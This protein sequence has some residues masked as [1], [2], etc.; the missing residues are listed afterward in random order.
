M[1][2]E[3]LT[4]EK[5]QPA[6]GSVRKAKRVG[7]G[8]GSGHGDRATRGNKGAQS[9]S[10]YRKKP[11]FE[12]GQMPLVRRV[13][14]RGFRPLIRVKWDEVGVDQILQIDQEEI[15]P[16]VL[17]KWGLVSGN[18]PVVIIGGKG[19]VKIERPLKVAAHRITQSVRDL[20]EQA[21]GEVT[22]LELPSQ[23]RKVK[24]GPKSRTVRA[25][26]SSRSSA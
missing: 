25:P 17:A 3:G 24:K 14:K 16:Q 9:R 5:L 18:K 22:I 7:R 19:E 6:P 1:P 10:G 11:G 26:L 8:R 15:T 12:G 4:L 23:F 21:G 20:I 13:P 2:L